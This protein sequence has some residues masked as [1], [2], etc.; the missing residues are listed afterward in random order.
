MTTIHFYDKLRKEGELVITLNQIYYGVV[1]LIVLA[2]GGYIYSLNN[3]ISERDNRIKAIEKNYSDLQTDFLAEQLKYSLTESALIK[4]S[5]TVTKQKFDYDGAVKEL[6][7]WREQANRFEKTSKYL[8]KPEI[9][10][11]GNCEDVN[12]YFNSIDGFD[13]DSL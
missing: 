11:R 5:D 7:E 13:L 2:V 1:F 10:Q 8:P 3:D 9:I 12:D 6:S 4:L